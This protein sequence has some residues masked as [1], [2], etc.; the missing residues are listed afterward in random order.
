ML[1][2]HGPL[3]LTESVGRYPCCMSVVRTKTLKDDPP[4]RAA[5]VAR[6]YLYALNPGPPTMAR[7]APLEGSTDTIA[8]VPKRAFPVT[9]SAGSGNVP[10]RFGSPNPLMTSLRALTASDWALGSRVVSM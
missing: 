1:N 5:W 3:P 8:T 7:T 10:G 2:V 4:W 6:L 9:G